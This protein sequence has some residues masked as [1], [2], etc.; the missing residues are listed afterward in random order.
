MEI[1]PVLRN[2]HLGI[3]LD[4]GEPGLLNKIRA[5]ESTL[6]ITAQ[7]QRNLNR[8][9]NQAVQEGRTVIWKDITYRPSIAGSFMGI[10]AGHTTVISVENPQKETGLPSDIPEKGPEI[11]SEAGLPDDLNP[12]GQ[13]DI[14]APS[15]AI[16]PPPAE[17]SLDELSREAVLLQA[18]IGKLEAEIEE[19][20]S[21]H[22][23][24]E[25]DLGAEQAS[26]K[27]LHLSRELRKKEE[28]LNKIAME[29]LIK[30]Q[31]NLMSAVNQ[32]FIQE[33]Q[34]PVA[35]IKTAYGAGSGTPS[36]GFEKIA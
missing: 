33:S 24:G 22:G 7:E 26:R 21:G 1:K 32:D 4:P 28:E 25:N 17:D 23:E 8:L 15:A 20:E 9:A 16:D 19:A 29:R 12:S 3:K 31:S 10:A 27:K 2:P 14:S 18:S 6:R 5:S 35:M 11:S 13:N 36:L 30:M 34:A